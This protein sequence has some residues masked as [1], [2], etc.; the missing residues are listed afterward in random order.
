MQ[1]E[2]LT[3]SWQFVGPDEDD[4][5]ER[6]RYKELLKAQQDAE[7]AEGELQRA[8]EGIYGLVSALRK[9]GIEES[10]QG[11]QGEGLADNYFA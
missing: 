10:V 1:W 9:W 5:P 6:E 4:W 11:P 2:Y 8:S 3:R 7:R